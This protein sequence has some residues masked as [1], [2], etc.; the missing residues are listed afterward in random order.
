MITVR[1]QRI[2]GSSIKDR[3]LPFVPRELKF[4]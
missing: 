3:D 1:S 4:E 2:V